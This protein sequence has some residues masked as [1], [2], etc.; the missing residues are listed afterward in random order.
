MFEHRSTVHIHPTVLFNIIDAV[1]RRP[2][3]S[4]RTLGTLLGADHEGT[5]EIANSFPVSFTETA[6]SLYLDMEFHKEMVK[7]NQA[8]NKKEIVVGWSV[9]FRSHCI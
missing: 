9:G 7:L 4:E 6:D 1:L 2:T 3:G 8:V 5:I